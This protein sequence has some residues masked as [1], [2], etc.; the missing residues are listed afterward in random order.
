MPIEMPDGL[1]PSPTPD[2]QNPTPDAVVNKTGEPDALPTPSGEPEKTFTQKQVD[3]MVANRV[4]SAL[5]AELAKLGADPEAGVTLESLQTD[6]QN[7]RTE[8]Q[9]LQAQNSVRDYANDAT[10]QLN[11]PPT[12]MSAVLELVNARLEYQ[13]GK[14][15]NLKEAFAAVKSIAPA[16]FAVQTTNIHAGE[17]RTAQAGPVN[18]NKVLRDLAASKNS[19][20]N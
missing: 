14:P 20:A 10:N 7:L 11:I 15:T 9:T 13:D 1:N 4:K 2:P 12:N 17:G 19:F 6:L 8:N 5:K 3:S 18:M 16:L